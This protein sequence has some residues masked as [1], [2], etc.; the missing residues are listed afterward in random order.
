VKYR[1]NPTESK[2]R[3]RALRGDMTDSEKK[4][5]Y[6]LQRRGLENCKFR[7]QYGIG[8]YIVDF[9]CAELRL[10]VEVDG[11]SHFTDEGRGHD[12]ARDEYIRS[13]GIYIVRFTNL[14]VKLA[15]EGVIDVIADA[16]RNMR[17]CTSPDPS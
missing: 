13:N 2:E 8:P 6:I 3:R 9:Y 5:W 7:R 11:D 10:A 12:R 16:I 4:L 1:F 17:A 15:L 14:D